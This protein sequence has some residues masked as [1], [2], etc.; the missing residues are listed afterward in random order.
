MLRGQPGSGVQSRGRDRGCNSGIGQTREISYPP[1]GPAQSAALPLRIPTLNWPHCMFLPHPLPRSLTG[2][3]STTSPLGFLITI[4]SWAWKVMISTGPCSIILPMA[5]CRGGGGGG[6]R[7]GRQV[8]ENGPQ[9]LHCCCP[10]R[11]RPLL[12][13]PRA[14]T[15]HWPVSGRA[16]PN[17][18][19]ECEPLR[20]HTGS[21]D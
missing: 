17:C 3:P 10:S 6:A 16:L 4:T 19:A 14:A 11:C 18:E 21:P 9:P 20:T 5:N 2:S 15:S 13:H 1:P 8:S 7:Q 12:Q